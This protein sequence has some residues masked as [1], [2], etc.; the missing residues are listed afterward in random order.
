MA[1]SLLPCFFSVCSGGRLAVFGCGDMSY[2]YFCGAVDAIEERLKK[3][4]ASL[5][6]ES[7]RIDGEPEETEVSEWIEDVINAA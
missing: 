7:L 2:T 6:S 5:V 3:L 4:G 1:G